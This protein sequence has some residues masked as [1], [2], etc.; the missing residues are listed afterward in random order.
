[1]GNFYSR[2]Q[3]LSVNL[4]EQHKISLLVHQHGCHFIDLEDHLPHV[5]VMLKRCFCVIGFFDPVIKTQI[6]S[7]SRNPDGYFQHPASRIQCILLILNLD[8]ILQ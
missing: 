2:D 4:L 1:M 7:P 5:T 6:S 8:P 3:R